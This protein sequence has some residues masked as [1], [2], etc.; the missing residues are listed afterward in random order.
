MGG[1]SARF[2]EVE[3][4]T[5]AGDART[6]RVRTDNAEEKHLVFICNVLPELSADWYKDP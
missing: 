1:V 3:D 5:W 2:A 4:A 6:N